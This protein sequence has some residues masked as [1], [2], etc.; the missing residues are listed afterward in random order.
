MKTAPRLLINEMPFLIE[1]RAKTFYKYIEEVRT[2]IKDW[3]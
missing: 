3:C 1:K 2:A